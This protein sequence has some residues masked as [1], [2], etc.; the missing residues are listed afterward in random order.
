MPSFG[1]MSSLPWPAAAAVAATLAVALVS[2]EAVAETRALR[3]DYQAHEGCPAQSAFFDR[4]LARTS[5]ARAAAPGEA[6][7]DV[8]VRI[9]RQAPKSLGRIVL[10]KSSGARTREVSSDDCD[11]VVSALALITALAIDPNASVTPRTPAAPASPSPDPAGSGDP[12]GQGAPSAPAAPPLPDPR[13]IPL[14]PIPVPWPLLV[15]S[16]LVRRPRPAAGA[17]PVVGPWVGGAFVAASFAVTP[18]ALLGGGLFAERRFGSER[19]VAL[20][21]ALEGA[22]TGSFEVGPAG[23]AFVRGAARLQGCPFLRAARWLSV[24]ACLG[25]EVGFLRGEGIQ[26]GAIASVSADTVPWAGLGLVPRAALD[27]G[28]RAVVGIEGGPTFSL[29][30]RSFVFKEPDYTIYDLPAVTWAFRLD[31]GIRF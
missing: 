26:R 10:W 17:E 15:P 4:V 28:E 31:V 12:A 30:Q 2:G 18:Q 29:V 14:T 7:L 9:A 11:E 27:V 13:T 21:L 1:R 8:W 22:A 3:V 19:G 6:A 25:G 5:R 20:R 23:V 16:P 24:A